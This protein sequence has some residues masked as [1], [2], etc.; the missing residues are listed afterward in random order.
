ML[1]RAGSR[2]RAGTAAASHVDGVAG[3]HQLLGTGGAQAVGPHRGGGAAP[4]AGRHVA[5]ACIVGHHQ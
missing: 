2:G 1:E 3:E 4:D 5:D